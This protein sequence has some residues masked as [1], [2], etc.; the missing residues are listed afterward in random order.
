MEPNSKEVYI[1]VI[2]KWGVQRKI[3]SHIILVFD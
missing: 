1:W 2:K 3:Q